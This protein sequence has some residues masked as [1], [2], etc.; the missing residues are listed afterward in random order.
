M[1][2]LFMTIYPNKYSFELAYQTSPQS[3]DI[4]PSHQPP[5]LTNPLF[6]IVNKFNLFPIIY[7]THNACTDFDWPDGYP[8]KLSATIASTQSE[9]SA[10]KTKQI[11]TQD[12]YP[13]SPINAP[14]PKGFFSLPENRRQKMNTV[15]MA[16][17]KPTPPNTAVMVLIRGEKLDE[18]REMVPAVPAMTPGR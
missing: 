6:Q 2:T 9:Y 5:T 11:G 13:L 8:I 17:A 14:V 3:L 4:S 15:V 12:A 16:I 18:A 7:K 10:P 1:T